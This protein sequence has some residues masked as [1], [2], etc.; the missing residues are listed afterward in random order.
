MRANNHILAVIGS[1]C[2]ITFL[3]AGIAT[4]LT[5]VANSYLGYGFYRSILYILADSASRF[6]LP[7]SIVVAAVAIGSAL[8][9]KRGAPVRRA[10]PALSGLAGG[11][12]LFAGVAYTHNL[13]DFFKL[14][15]TRHA[16]GGVDVPEA[17]FRW[18]VWRDNAAIGLL[19]LAAGVATWALFRFALRGDRGPGRRYWRT[20]GHPVAALAALAAIALPAAG[21]IVMRGSG[22]S[23]PNFI[24]VSLDTLRADHLGVYGYARDTSPEI[25]SLANESFTFDWAFCQGP[26][27]DYSHT[28]MFTSLYPTVHGVD[29]THSLAG[30][31][32]TLAEYLREA[33]YR[34]AAC[35]DGGYMR[36]VFG[37]SQGFECYD[38]FKMKG[39]P[40]AVPKVL[41]W[42][43][44][45]LADGPF[46]LFL[47]TFD[48]HSPYEP[49]KRFQGM[50][51]DPD[52][53][54]VNT[55][56]QALSDIR[57]RVVDDPLAGPG[58]SE[59]EIEFMK[60]RY[61]EGIRWIDGWVGRLVDGLRERGL[62]E[63]TWVVILSDHGEE[64]TEHGT[65]LHGE[66]YNTNI[67]VP[68]IIRP[69]GWPNRG[70]RIEHIVEL[71]DVMPTF[72][73]LAGIEP[74]DTIEGKSLVPLFKGQTA[75]WKDVA[76]SEHPG[77]A[78]WQRSI[79]TPDLHV[80]TSSIPGDLQVYDY[81][82]DPLEQVNLDDRASADE[83]RGMLLALDEWT[84]EQ[85]ELVEAWGGAKSLKIDSETEDQLRSLGYVK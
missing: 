24:L 52:A 48:I 80:I 5:S 85:L 25:D 60:G 67:R 8:W 56:T 28:S 50:F 72:L 61:D 38:D 34:T 69:P 21:A 20:M 59:D 9:I 68:L 78:G 74:V 37:F 18:P 39:M 73:D 10:V 13:N 55:D 76:F 75:A 70:C 33:G 64:F 15:H 43:D 63:K 83:V 27:T 84:R 65:V 42:L 77:K 57:S 49:P 22:P 40:R 36:R 32:L 35:T 1:I 82:S 4:A 58:L 29:L 30:A 53:K 2:L 17:L 19:A 45:G 7:A 26:R 66:L 14:W 3:A 46:F 41:G 79:I 62:L 44:K 51:T 6:R 23:R 12:V 31:R 81:R 71:I 11:L 16:L 54:S 47:H